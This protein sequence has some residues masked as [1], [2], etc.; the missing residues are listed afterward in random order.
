M[1]GTWDVAAQIYEALQPL[2]L[3]L[4]GGT[5]P[6][7]DPLVHTAHTA[8]GFS[9]LL[10]PGGDAAAPGTHLDGEHGIDAVF[11]PGGDQGIDHAVA[12]QADDIDAVAIHKLRDLPIPGARH[13]IED[14]RDHQRAVLEADILPIMGIVELRAGQEHLPGAVIAKAA[15]GIQ[16]LPVKIFIIGIEIAQLLHAQDIPHIADQGAQVQTHRHLTVLPQPHGRILRHTAHVH[17]QAGQ[18]FLLPGGPVRQGGADH[19]GDAGDAGLYQADQTLAVPDH[20]AAVR[21]L[22]Q[23]LL[24]EGRVQEHMAADAGIPVEVEAQL[25]HDLP[26]APAIVAGAPVIQGLLGGDMALRGP[27]LHGLLPVAEADQ[28]HPFIV[29]IAEH[30]QGVFPMCH[31]STTSPSSRISSEPEPTKI[32]NRPGS[33]V[34]L[35]RISM[36]L[37]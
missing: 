14:R 1:V 20:P 10:P 11:Q 6:G 26:V 5:V 37:N 16:D 36:S 3:R 25:L 23:S 28:G 13:L 32:R 30:R 17:L 34:Q 21:P 33:T 15:E 4:H 19:G 31:H 18:I 22:L 7:E 8:D 9:V 24:Q 27:F 35:Y 29:L 12:V 2:H